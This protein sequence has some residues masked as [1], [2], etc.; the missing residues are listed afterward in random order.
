MS[1]K[2][3]HPQNMEV[4]RDVLAPTAPSELEEEVE[5]LRKE[6]DDLRK[7]VSHLMRYERAVNDTAYFED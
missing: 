6:V 3:R 2:K 5:R 7:I 4:H 1:D